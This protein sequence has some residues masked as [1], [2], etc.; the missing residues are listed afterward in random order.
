MSRMDDFVSFPEVLDLAPYMAPNRNDYKMA[1]TPL[2]PRA[3]Y[4]DW[5][6]PDQGHNLD[7]VNY[8]LYGTCLTHLKCHTN[9]SAVVVHLGTMI[10]GHYIAYCLVDPE[11]MFGEMPTDMEI[12][13]KMENIDK[14]RPD[15]SGKDRRVWC[16]CS[17]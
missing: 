2:G 6:S 16:F 14:C 15:P 3:A 9:Y 17:E 12:E 10:G 7:P 11:K 1:N 5:A 4:M 13:R 8:K